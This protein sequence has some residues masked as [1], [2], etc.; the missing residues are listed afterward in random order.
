MTHIY[1]SRTETEVQGTVHIELV[2]YITITSA[3]IE[4]A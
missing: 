2:S 4:V 3:T 1:K